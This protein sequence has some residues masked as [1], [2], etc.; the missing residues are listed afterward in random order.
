[1]SWT[2]DESSSVI[3]ELLTDS[4][5]VVPKEGALGVTRV[6]QGRDEAQRILTTAGVGKEQVSLLA[7]SNHQVCAGSLTACWRLRVTAAHW[8]EQWGQRK[9]EKKRKENCI[10]E[11]DVD[12]F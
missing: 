6:V 3:H 5:T 4:F 11:E 7:K 10:L 2:D 12:Y 8:G 1:M 9:K